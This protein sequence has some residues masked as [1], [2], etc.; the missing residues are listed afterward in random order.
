MPEADA[1]VGSNRSERGTQAGQTGESGFK[2]CR[3]VAEVPA[4]AALVLNA[5]LCAFHRS[6]SDA[7]PSGAKPLPMRGEY[8]RG[9]D[10]ADNHVDDRAGAKREERPLAGAGQFAKAGCKSNA[11]EAKNE[12]PAA[13]IL[14]WPDQRRH[15]RLVEVAEAIAGGH[16]G[17]EQRRQQ[18]ADDEFRKTP[19]DFRRF[20]LAPGFGAVPLRGRDD[21]QHKGPNADPHIAPDDL[22]QRVGKDRLIAGARYVAVASEVA[23]G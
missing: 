16:R 23:V 14:D 13:Q 19:P 21:R 6:S 15:H 12:G 7:A 10:K 11:E 18:E 9:Q 22:D 3:V 8:D 1:V 17:D 20:R 2:I 5:K 4:R